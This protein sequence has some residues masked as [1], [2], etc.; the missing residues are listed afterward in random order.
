[1]IDSAE[2]AK[3]SAKKVYWI[4][5][6]AFGSLLPNGVKEWIGFSMEPK[7]RTKFVLDQVIRVNDLGTDVFQYINLS[8]IKN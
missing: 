7:A 6:I 8:T 3:E 5:Y 2:K 1:M 4:N